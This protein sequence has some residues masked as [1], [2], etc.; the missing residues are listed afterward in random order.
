MGQG[1]DREQGWVP[2]GGM[3][4]GGEPGMG[5]DGRE[6]VFPVLTPF[7]TSSRWSRNCMNRLIFQLVL[8]FCKCSQRLN[9]EDP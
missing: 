4:G 7:S 6:G 8:Q 3:Q 9:A 2:A 1:P 5:R